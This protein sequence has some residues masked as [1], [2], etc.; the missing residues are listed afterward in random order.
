ML[1]MNCVIYEL[2]F[3]KAITKKL[4]HQNTRITYNLH[5]WVQVTVFVILG[6]FF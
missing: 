2:H 4:N 1:Q 3:N 5:I 6:M